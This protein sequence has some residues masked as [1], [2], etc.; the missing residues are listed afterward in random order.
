ME[1]KGDGPEITTTTAPTAKSPLD[2]K[3]T[4]IKEMI[5]EARDTETTEKRTTK[6]SLQE[7]P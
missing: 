1:T 7:N 3:T 4:A 2:T 5:A 6:S